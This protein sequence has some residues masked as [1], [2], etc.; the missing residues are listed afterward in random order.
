M[1]CGS[2]SDGAAA[3][4]GA[5]RS[6]PLVGS[7]NVDLLALKRVFD[8]LR[9]NFVSQLGFPSGATFHSLAYLSGGETNVDLGALATWEYPRTHAHPTEDAAELNIE[10]SKRRALCDLLR[11]S[12]PDIAFKG[13][14][15]A[16]TLDLGE[17]QP[18]VSL[19]SSPPFHSPAAVPLNTSA[20]TRELDGAA[21]PVAV[22]RRRK[23]ETVASV[24]ALRGTADGAETFGSGLFKLRETESHVRPRAIDLG[25]AILL[26]GEA[27]EAPASVKLVRDDQSGTSKAASSVFAAQ[28]TDRN[29]FHTDAAGSAHMGLGCDKM[30]AI[31][32]CVT[33]RTEPQLMLRDRSDSTVSGGNTAGGPSSLPPPLSVEPQGGGDGTRG[34]LIAFPSDGKHGTLGVAPKPAGSCNSTEAL[35]TAS[36]ASATAT[37]LLPAW[38][39][40]VN[41]LRTGVQGAFALLSLDDAVAV[42]DAAPG[43]RPE[44]SPATKVT[45]SVVPSTRVEEDSKERCASRRTDHEFR[46][47]FQQATNG[48]GLARLHVTRPSVEPAQGS[49]DTGVRPRFLSG[50]AGRQEAVDVSEQRAERSALFLPKEDLNSGM[51]HDTTVLSAPHL[52]VRAGSRSATKL[53]ER[54]RMTDLQHTKAV[55]ARRALSVVPDVGPDCSTK[56]TA[57]DVRP[58]AFSTDETPGDLARPLLTLLSRSDNMPQ[59]NEQMAWRWGQ[60][61]VLPSEDST[62]AVSRRRSTCSGS[63]GGPEEALSPRVHSGFGHSD[64]IGERFEEQAKHRDLHHASP[65][66]LRHLLNTGRDS[67]RCRSAG[68][69]QEPGDCKTERCPS[70]VNSSDFQLSTSREQP[71]GAPTTT[72]GSW[73]SFGQSAEQLLAPGV[74]PESHQ[75]PSPPSWYS[76]GPVVPIRLPAGTDGSTEHGTETGVTNETQRSFED[77]ADATQEF[78][79][80]MMLPNVRVAHRIARLAGALCAGVSVGP[81]SSIKKDLLVYFQCR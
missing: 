21:E 54:S 10:R 24:T 22:K 79:S 45:T 12:P 63:L 37:L 39:R 60:A 62:S 78:R 8:I 59:S 29:Y 46:L 50:K 53:H 13:R 19:A 52:S 71:C 20:T 41:L 32:V 81:R 66:L 80:E 34:G 26:N 76:S 56:M 55:G 68:D 44:D 35:Q 72:A 73:Q 51:V 33:E 57:E 67:G 75:S 5:T 16:I 36:A 18:N 64:R 43:A 65:L 14:R 48:A 9:A 74:A 11:D 23:M 25:G 61:C 15:F 1:Y 17:L 7:N 42:G 4:P 47:A 70:R 30:E 38:P 6:T 58:A 28:W 69:S 2:S 3:Q 77:S 49:S 27:V 31:S 40:Q